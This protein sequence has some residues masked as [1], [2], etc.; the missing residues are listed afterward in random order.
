MQ[1]W[2]INTRHVVKKISHYNKKGWTMMNTAITC[3]SA[4]K[5]YYSVQYE[6]QYVLYA[7]VGKQFIIFSAK[8]ANAQIR[9]SANFYKMLHNSVSKQS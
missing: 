2:F 7:E 3:C 9:K 4:E 8:I 5:C 6:Q 1:D